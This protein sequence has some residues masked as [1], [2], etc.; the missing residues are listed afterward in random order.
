MII[1]IMMGI[2]RYGYH[3]QG[4]ENSSGIVGSISSALKYTWALTQTE[5]WRL[6]VP[7]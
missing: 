6:K 7:V 3:M 1:V 2:S 5:E 4:D